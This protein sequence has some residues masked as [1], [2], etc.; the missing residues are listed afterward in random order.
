METAI[1]QFVAE[2]LPMPRTRY[3]LFNKRE[4]KF[5]EHPLVGLWGTSE[6][7]EARAYLSACHEW[8]KADGLEHLA[9]DYVIWDNYSQKEIGMTQ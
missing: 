4:D 6:L 2:M 9:D 7:S 5:L 8:L 3:R 1:E